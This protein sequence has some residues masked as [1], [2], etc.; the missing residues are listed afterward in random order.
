MRRL[1]F[2]VISD[3]RMGGTKQKLVADTNKI[4]DDL[5]ALES[6]V[7]VNE[8]EL[9]SDKAIHELSFENEKQWRNIFIIAKSGRKTTWNKIYKT[10][11]KTYAPHYRFV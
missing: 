6:V 4:L 8:N 11:N 9:R 3:E 10:V 7:V 5:K 2:E 1:Y